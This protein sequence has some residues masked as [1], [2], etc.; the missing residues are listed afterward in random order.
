MSLSSTLVKN[1]KVEYYIKIK[2]H[3]SIV[4][5]FFYLCDLIQVS[6]MLYL[7][8]K[9]FSIKNLTIYDW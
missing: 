1:D 4:L 6:L 5:G 9:T 8:N 2:T 7:L 3:K